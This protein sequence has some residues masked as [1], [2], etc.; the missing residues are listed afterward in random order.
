M[1]QYY[2]YIMTNKSGTLYTGITNNLERRVFEHKHC[3]VEGFTKKY[4]LTRLVYYE[5]V[6]DALTAIKWE[7]QIKGWLRKK[8]IALIESVNPKWKDLSAEWLRDSSLRSE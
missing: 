7:K 1:R 6:G 5:A 3:L 2:V 8:K 4:K